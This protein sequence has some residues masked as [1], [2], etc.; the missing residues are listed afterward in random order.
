[1]SELIFVRHGQASFGAESYDKLSEIGARQVQILAEHW[2]SNQE[3]FDH[4]YSG[5]LMRQQETANLLL[6]LVGN[7]PSR[8][9]TQQ[10]SSQQSSSRRPPGQQPSGQQPVLHSGFNEYNG[11]PLIDIYLR[12][13][14]HSV[15]IGAGLSGP[16]R[17]RKL[18]QQVFEAATAKWLTDELRPG[19]SDLEFETWGAFQ[20]RVRAA[21]D[22]LMERHSKSSR[23]LVST[24]GGVIALVLQYVLQ[25]PDPQ[26]IAINWTITAR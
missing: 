7:P 8:P 12:D 1:M 9:A 26:T 6:P 4:I 17:E 21:V 15:G 24:S 23:V 11:T 3:Q 16:I 18:F 20:A 25:L 13:H 14:A 22:E 2:H 19:E 5:E 10:S